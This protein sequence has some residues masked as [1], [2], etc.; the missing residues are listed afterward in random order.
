[1]ML[2]KAH[3]LHTVNVILIVLRYNLII[4]MLKIIEYIW[5]IDQDECT[6]LF[7]GSRNFDLVTG[8][9]HFFLSSHWTLQDHSQEKSTFGP[10]TTVWIT[11]VSID[12]K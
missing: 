11:V 12:K 4:I 7:N 3:L 5:N 8:K 2:L 9:Y 6:Y 10:R 1:M